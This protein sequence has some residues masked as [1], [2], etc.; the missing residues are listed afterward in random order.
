[1][2]VSVVARNIGIALLFNAMFMFLSAAVSVV[3]DFD[4]AFSPLLLSGVITFTTGLFPLIFVRRHEEIHIKEGFT[5]IVLSWI[6]S[7]LFGMLPYV[8][9]GGE[10]SLINAWFE[11][12]SGY[13][14]TGG[15]ILQD[16][17]ALPKSLLFWRSST[18]F[19]GGI[20]VV[21]F[22]LLILPMVSTFK[23]RLTKL[24]MTSLSKENYRFRTK[25]AISVISSVFIGLTI[26]AAIAF[27]LAGMNLFDAVN[28]AFSVVT[29]GGFSTRNASIGAY[30]SWLIEFV[31]VVFM[32][33]GGM[34]F[35]LI[36]ST[37]AERSL[38]LF[39]SPITKFYLGTV[40][41]ATVL[42]SMDLFVHG[43]EGS[44]WENIWNSLFNVVSFIST[45]GFATVDTSVWPS[46]SILLL[47]FLSIQCA[48]S[49][50]TTGG[51]K[52]DRVFIF[53]KS[54][55]VQ[56]RM[57]MHPNAVIP[58]RVGNSIVENS[59]VSAVNL[60][61]AVYFL[62]MFIGAALLS[63]MGVDFL[64]AFS[65]S[66]ANLGNVGPGFG[67]V[68]SLGNYSEIPVMGK[69][70]LALQM[71]FGRLEIYSLIIMCSIWK[72]R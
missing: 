51:L 5:I 11:S 19:I 2:N 16:I 12:V 69:F 58:V 31:A 43:V 8:L 62:F 14:T 17:E 53:W 4:S 48:C 21:V 72:W 50:S 39:R 52:S 71:L 38:K 10:F 61:I 59:M 45:T 18:H 65:A 23:M 13:T 30:D 22:M 42:V 33:L 32:L 49:G 20:G 63:V 66:V 9:W 55:R 70:I 26:S 28:H 29:T 54:F 67:S 15:T 27:F 36:Y 40:A 24:E 60:Y 35:G 1:M 44:F 64:D 37:F 57:Q 46:L 41:V 47:I 3:Y 6:L 25:Q 34:H 56:L 68:G 7:C